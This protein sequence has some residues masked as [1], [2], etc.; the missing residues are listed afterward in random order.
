[1]EAELAQANAALLLCSPKRAQGA[2]HPKAGRRLK[3]KQKP[4]NK[5]KLAKSRSGPVCSKKGKLASLFF[6][7]MTRPLAQVYIL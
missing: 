6:Q 3:N 5:Q 7:H 1:V 2:A 4:K